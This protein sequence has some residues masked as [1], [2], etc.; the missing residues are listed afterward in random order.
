[1]TIIPFES[2][3][4]KITITNSRK[5]SIVLTEQEQ[6]EYLQWMKANRTALFEE[7]ACQDCDCKVFYVNEREKK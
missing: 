4:T 2:H 3:P 5:R 6:R 1:M 7:V